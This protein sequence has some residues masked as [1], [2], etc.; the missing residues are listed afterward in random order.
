MQ[1]GFT[2]HPLL[3][4]VSHTLIHHTAMT[5]TRDV[6]L[7]LE[8]DIGDT[9]IPTLEHRLP[10]LRLHPLPTIVN[11]SLFSPLAISFASSLANL[12]LL[13]ASGGPLLIT[14]ESPVGRL[15][16]QL[17]SV[18]EDGGLV[19]DTAGDEWYHDCPPFSWHFFRAHTPDVVVQRQEVGI[20]ALM[21]PLPSPTAAG[22]ETLPPIQVLVLIGV[23]HTEIVPFSSM[24]DSIACSG[25]SPPIAPFTPHSNL[26]MLLQRMFNSPQGVD[27]YVQSRMEFEAELQAE[28]SRLH[29]APLLSAAAAPM[30][31]IDFIPWNVDRPFR[32]VLKADCAMVARFFQTLSSFI[33]IQLRLLVITREPPSVLYSGTRSE[34][35][36]LPSGMN[37]EWRYFFVARVLHDHL[38]ALIAEIKAIHPTGYHIINADDAVI[39]TA[40]HSQQLRRSSTGP[41]VPTTCFS[42]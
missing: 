26:S 32:A 39:R 4:D 5:G 20:N 8:G 27:S 12:L 29:A 14:Y 21:Y 35:A 24:F 7:W 33:P 30:I 19:V 34:I 37:P 6:V 22:T 11:A 38:S 36:Q 17:R 42:I 16:R 2:D 1:L 28:V 3:L 9:F 40:Y 15:L 10:H 31:R 18:E 25:S 23:S 41:P 13:S